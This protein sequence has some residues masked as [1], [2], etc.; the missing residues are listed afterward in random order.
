MFQKTVLLIFVALDDVTVALKVMEV[1]CVD[2]GGGLEFHIKSGISCKFR[3]FFYSLK[4][5]QCTSVFGSLFR[6][7]RNK[8][9][10]Y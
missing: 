7:E 1:S 8:Y 6:L 3:L 4:N 5:K 9:D 10:R 2:V